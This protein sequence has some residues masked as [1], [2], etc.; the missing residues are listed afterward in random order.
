MS[1]LA[2]FQE[3]FASAL[4]RA[5][6]AAHETWQAQPAFAVYRNTVMK[7]CIDALEAN[8][9]SVLRL[10]GRDWFRS[11]CALYVESQPPSDGALLHYGQA[12]ADFL[13]RFEPAD[14]LTYL[15]DVARLDRYWTEA[16]VAADGATVDA[17]QLA[18]LSPQELA[19]CRLAPHPAARWAWFDNQPIYSIWQRNR[20]P[21]GEADADDELAWHGEGALLTRPGHQ[22]LWEPADRAACSFLDAC[23]RGIGLAE[24]T[25]HALHADPACDLMAMLSRL[26]Q[27]G[28]LAA[29]PHQLFEKESGANA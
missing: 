14:E 3:D 29:P 22:V 10:V 16:H 27:A 26:L 4:F 20:Q 21:G 9:P 24:A 28:A 8:Y 12:F 11:A 1:T 18:S 17:A 2:R 13:Q 7:G 5:D 25:E 15:P 19:A 6:S 23:A